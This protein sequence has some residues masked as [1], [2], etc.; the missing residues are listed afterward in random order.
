MRGQ[1]QKKDPNIQ[2]VFLSHPHGYPVVTCQSFT[3]VL[4]QASNFP[5]TPREDP[6]YR[7]NAAALNAFPFNHTQGLK[8]TKIL[9]TPKSFNKA[10]ESHLYQVISQPKD[11]E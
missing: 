1:Q 11:P 6:A 7:L 5:W 8:I 10:F 2:K 9:K 3:L 4:W